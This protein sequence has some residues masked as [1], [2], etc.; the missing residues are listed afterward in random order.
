MHRRH[1]I[2]TDAAPISAEILV[3]TLFMRALMH[4]ARSRQSEPIVA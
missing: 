4:V 2:E 1:R 3:D